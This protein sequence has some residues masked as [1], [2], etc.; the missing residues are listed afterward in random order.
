MPSKTRTRCNKFL[1]RTTIR[2]ARHPP[3]LDKIR[4]NPI[5]PKKIVHR[6]LSFLPHLPSLPLLLCLSASLPLRRSVTLRLCRSASPPVN[7]ATTVSLA[8][9]VQSKIVPLE[10]DETYPSSDYGENWSPSPPPARANRSSF[11]DE[12]HTYSGA[13]SHR[14]QRSYNTGN[15]QKNR[16]HAFSKP[17]R[18]SRHDSPISISSDNPGADVSKLRLEAQNYK[19]KLEVERLRGRVEALSYGLISLY[20]IHMLTTMLSEIHTTRFFV[21]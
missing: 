20:I 10:D 8:M 2:H 18:N 7:P 3:G 9:P 1:I 13:V 5:P 16:A 4:Y 14:D 11:E 19:L 17:P 15:I 12:S 21:I 6:C